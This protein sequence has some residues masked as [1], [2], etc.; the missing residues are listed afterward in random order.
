MDHN[1]TAFGSTFELCGQSGC[2]QWEMYWFMGIYEV[3]PGLMNGFHGAVLLPNGAYLG[4]GTVG[5]PYTYGCIMSE[6]SNA[7]KLY[8]WA[9]DGTVVEIISSGF[10][11]QSQLA[12][13]WLAQGG[14]A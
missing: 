7:E 8:H 11:P 14:S 1:D 13:E 9:E 5:Y 4:G 6:N 3:V 10:P 2:G 12:R